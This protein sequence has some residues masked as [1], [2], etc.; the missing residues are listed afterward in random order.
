MKAQLLF[1]GSTSD[2]IEGL[3]K[4]AIAFIT[5]ILCDLIWFQF[6]DYGPIITKSPINVFS[7]LIAWILLS[8][9][10]GV[11]HQP[12][13][14]QTSVVYGMLVGLVVYGVYNGTNYA[15]VKNWPMN[16]AFMD[17]MW[18]I[19]VSGVAS[20]SVYHFY[21]KRKKYNTY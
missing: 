7:A 10:L 14:L 8:S 13:S 11:L 18:G 20:A 15:I 17:T 6:M 1:F 21:H 4:G 16:I 12:D 2:S 3:K 19:F 9:A 5:L